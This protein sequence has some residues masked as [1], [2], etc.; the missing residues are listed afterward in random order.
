[1]IV[2]RDKINVT[3]ELRSFFIVGTLWNKVHFKTFINV[4]GDTFC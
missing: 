1:M 3:S 4:F 2:I